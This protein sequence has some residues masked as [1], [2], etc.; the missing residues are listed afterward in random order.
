MPRLVTG[1]F[2]ERNEAE[3]AVEALKAQGIPAENIYVEREVEPSTE[4]GR[5][6][7]EVTHLE[8]E[9]RFAGLESGL[10]IG[11]AVGL[12]AGMSVG[13]VGAEMSAMMGRIEPKDGLSPMLTNVWLTSL[14][15]ALLGLITGGLIGWVV[16]HTLNRLGAGPPLP[17]QETLVTVRTDEEMLDKVYDALFNARARHLHVSHGAPA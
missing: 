8:Q 3:R 14:L 1:L 13:M 6:G 2:Y 16:D 4:M 11:L 5:K 12:L 9:R 17:A 15:G 10:I 7:G